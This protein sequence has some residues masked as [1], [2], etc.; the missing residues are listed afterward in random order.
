MSHSALAVVTG[1]FSYTV[2]Y[3]ARRLIDQGVPVSDPSVPVAYG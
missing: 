2:G 3:V 1:A